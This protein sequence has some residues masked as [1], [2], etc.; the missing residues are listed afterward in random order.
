MC[1]L[2]LKRALLVLGASVAIAAAPSPAPSPTV[3]PLHVPVG[4]DFGIATDEPDASGKFHC[5][6]VTPSM[7]AF[8]G[9][10]QRIVWV[11][12]R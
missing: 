8:L 12:G 11:C 7:R 9:L 10:P 3:K 6:Y 2:E 1:A 5:D 4:V